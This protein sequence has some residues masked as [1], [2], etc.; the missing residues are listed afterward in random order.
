MLLD[1][2]AGK[3][4]YKVLVVY[5]ELFYA[6]ANTYSNFDELCMHKTHYKAMILY[7]NYKNDVYKIKNLNEKSGRCSKIL[8]N[9]TT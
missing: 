2:L 9:L 7:L 6:V 5:P 8:K 4:I 3:S 1:Y